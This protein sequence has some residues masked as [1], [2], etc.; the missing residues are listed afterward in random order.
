[1]TIVSDPEEV[2]RLRALPPPA[3]GR[4]PSPDTVAL[5]E[6]K[7]LRFVGKVPNHRWYAMARER[8]GVR[9]THRESADST[10]FVWIEWPE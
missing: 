10:L 1:M 7:V 9:R 4:Q 5:L 2:R 8:G 3:K 6:G